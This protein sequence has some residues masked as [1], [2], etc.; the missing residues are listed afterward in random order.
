MSKVKCTKI[1]WTLHVDV[2]VSLRITLT[3]NMN[4]HKSSQ[5][6]ATWNEPMQKRW[7]IK[8]NVK[9]ECIFC[10]QVFIF[11]AEATLA[12]NFQSELFAFHV[13]TT[14]LMHA[15]TEWRTE[16]SEMYKM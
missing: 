3:L 10:V 8:A 9:K 12:S 6:A 15:K 2:V 13:F 16:K 11:F 4:I 7:K 1:K 5:R 14:P